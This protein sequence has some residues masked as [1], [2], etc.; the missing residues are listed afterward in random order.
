MFDSHSRAAFGNPSLN[1]AS[2]LLSFRTLEEL[3][4][5]IKIIHVNQLFNLTPVLITDGLQSQFNFAPS[6]GKFQHKRY[7]ASRQFRCGTNESQ[8]HPVFM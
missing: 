8:L 7:I 1:G 4:I 2:V 3:C 6:I 5:Y